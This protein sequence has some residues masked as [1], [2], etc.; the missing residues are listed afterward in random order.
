M[1]QLQW[2]AQSWTPIPRNGR[3]SKPRRT[4]TILISREIVESVRDMEKGL[5][6]VERAF[7]EHGEGRTRM[8]AKMLLDL[9]EVKGDFRALPAY[10]SALEALGVKWVNSHPENR[11]RALP[12]VMG[13]IILS[14][15]AT[16][17]PLAIMDGTY[18]TAVRTGAASGVATRHLARVDSRRLALI[19]CGVQA[20]FQLD[21][22]RRLFRFETIT[23]HDPNETAMASVEEAFPADAGRFRRSSDPE[24]CVAGADVIVT[25][26]PS[27]SPVLRRDWIAAGAHI[28]AVGADAPGKQELDPEI[29]AAGRV[30]VDDLPQ[31]IHGGEINVAIRT[32]GYSADRIAAHLGE[33]FCARKPARTDPAEITVF[34]STG[35]A[36]HDIAAARFV[37]E[38]CRQAGTGL[39]IRF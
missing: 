14:D 1:S 3:M 24:Q 16:A 25:T 35:L 31:A 15:P 37:Y 27:R 2:F 18:L 7:R 20:P 38:E 26:T 13:L 4:E 12:T 29:L 6:V 19:G 9:P 30:I 21:A 5:A 36:I 28:N 34:D 22:L 11:D 39:R 33:V 17:V 8:P 23:L 10:L 32:G